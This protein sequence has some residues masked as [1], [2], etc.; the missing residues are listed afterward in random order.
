MTRFYSIDVERDLLERV[1]LVRRW[2]G[3]GTAGRTGL[4]EHQEEGRG[5][6]ALAAI[7]RQKRRRGYRPS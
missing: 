3:I 2:S 6:V 5:L 1:V 7:E 4:D